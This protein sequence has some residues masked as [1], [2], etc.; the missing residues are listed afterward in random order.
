MKVFTEVSKL[1][2]QRGGGLVAEQQEGEERVG[3][4]KIL[5]LMI[6]IVLSYWLFFL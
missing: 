4:I 3:R 2:G 6:L 1:T 5:V